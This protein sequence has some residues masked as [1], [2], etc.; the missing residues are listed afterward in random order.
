MFFSTEL[1]VQNYSKTFF[2]NEVFDADKCFSSYLH[3]KMCA[4]GALS[5]TLDVFVWNSNLLVLVK[6]WLMFLN[7]VH[8]ISLKP[9]N[10]GF[11]K[12][13][14][15]HFFIW[16]KIWNIVLLTHS[17]YLLV[18]T[19]TTHDDTLKTSSST[20]YLFNQRIQRLS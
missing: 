15:I 1:C 8:K 11:N 4:K 17:W 6:Y 19:N 16:N 7:Q 9:R 14:D 2:I 12:L 13:I 10:F 20:S 18:P 3:K 5:Q